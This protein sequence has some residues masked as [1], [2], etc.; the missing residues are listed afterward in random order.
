MYPLSYYI[1][2][3]IMTGPSLL[4]KVRPD[5]VLKFD[6]LNQNGAASISEYIYHCNAQ[7]PT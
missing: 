4:S 2:Q 1:L 5:L 7:K 3:F 6:P